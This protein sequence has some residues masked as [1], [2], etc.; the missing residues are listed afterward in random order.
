MGSHG[1]VSGDMG[2][3]GPA[4]LEGAH[5]VG[6]IDH[7]YMVTHLALPSKPKGALADDDDDDEHIF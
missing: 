1:R 6:K 5:E 2:L 4:D 3:A 7:L